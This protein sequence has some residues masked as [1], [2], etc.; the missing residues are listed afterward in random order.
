[1]SKKLIDGL[2]KELFDIHVKRFEELEA[3]VQ[4]ET[5]AG[6]VDPETVERAT[7]LLRKTSGSLQDLNKALY[8]ASNSIEDFY[9]VFNSQKLLVD[10]I[11]DTLNKIKEQESS[12]E[13]ISVYE[14]EYNKMYPIYELL[15]WVK[16][17]L[18]LPRS[19]KRQKV[20]RRK[21]L[22]RINQEFLPIKNIEK[23]LDSL[24]TFIR[25]EIE[26]IE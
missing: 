16:D 4:R 14:N 6:M 19:K 17:F 20:W 10:S 15:S 3:I 21:N 18:G 9:K 13:L 1:M 7:F 5:K 2:R 24:E 23:E 26:G 12:S 25:E 8:S 11:L 22:G